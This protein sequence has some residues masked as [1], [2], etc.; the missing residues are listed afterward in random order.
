MCSLDALP[1][2][3]PCP[4]MGNVCSQVGDCLPNI[5]KMNQNDGYE[6]GYLPF[7]YRIILYFHVSGVI[8]I[9][10][11]SKY[12]PLCQGSERQMSCF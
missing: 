7:R 3:G 1:G 9:G 6:F 4:P 5:P 11:V 8:Q 10:S 12:V 2:E